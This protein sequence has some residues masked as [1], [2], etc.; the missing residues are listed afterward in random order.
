MLAKSQLIDESDVATQPTPVFTVLGL[1]TL[2]FKT[3]LAQASKMNSP[4]NQYNSQSVQGNLG[5]YQ[6]SSQNLETLQYIKKGSVSEVTGQ[7]GSNA[8]AINEDAN[9]TGKNG[10]NSA[11]DFLNNQGEQETAI[12]A[13]WKYNV[14]WLTKNT[15][16]FAETTPSSQIG[17]L[18]VAQ[19]TQPQTVSVFNDYLLGRNVEG[20]IVDYTGSHTLLDYFNAGVVAYDFGSNIQKA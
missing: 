14:D 11:Q 5:K 17:F 13:L 19:L 4:N 6:F 16:F 20:N 7:P 8:L 3:I 9:W 10:C 18:F 2:H 1:R 15:S 12:L